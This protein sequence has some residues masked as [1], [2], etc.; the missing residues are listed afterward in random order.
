MVGYFAISMVV[1]FFTWSSVDDWLEHDI[2]HGNLIVALLKPVHFLSWNYF[3]ELGMNILSILLEMIPILII[4][5]IFFSL[6]LP[7]SINAIFFAVSIFLASLMYTAISFCIGLTAFWLNRIGG[8]RRMKRILMSF[9]SGG[10]IPLVF[11][12]SWYQNISKYLPFQ[13]LRYESIN[14]YLGKYTVVQMSQIV[15]IQIIWSVA[16]LT[17]GLLIWN[18]AFKKFAGAGT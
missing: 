5:I 4:S 17:L 13:Y 6:K 8:I 9:L 16:L 7:S 2:R 3:F 15:L 10:M 14:I 12:P 18:K 11:F 1:G